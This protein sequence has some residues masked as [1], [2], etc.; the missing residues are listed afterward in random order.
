MPITA[1]SAPTLLGD[2][3]IEVLAPAIFPIVG[4]VTLAPGLGAQENVA[5][6]NPTTVIDDGVLIVD[7]VAVLP[8]STEIT[9]E[10]E[11]GKF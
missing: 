3:Q 8:V 10:L 5:Y 9:I 4:V 6:S 11:V 1:L 2:L 7:T